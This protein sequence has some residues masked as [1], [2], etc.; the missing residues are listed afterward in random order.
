MTI[1]EDFRDYR[2]TNG[3]S[4]RTIKDYCYWIQ[5]FFEFTNKP[6]NE[7]TMKDVTK[8]VQHMQGKKNVPSTIN[9]AISAINSFFDFCNDYGIY[10]NK[11]HYK[12]IKD[13]EKKARLDKRDTLAPNQFDEFVFKLEDYF[14]E[15][16]NFT[17]ARKWVVL[18]LLIYGVLRKFEATNLLEKN[19]ERLPSG[20][21]KIEFIGKGGAWE[22]CTLPASFQEP[23][24]L[25][26]SFKRKW[27]FD[28]PNLLCTFNNK[29]MYETAFNNDVDWMTKFTGIDLSLSPHRFRH[30]GLN[31][32]KDHDCPPEKVRKAARHKNIKT[33][34]DNYFHNYDNL[35][36]QEAATSYFGR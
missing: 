27:K 20:L 6:Y 35:A 9:L 1:I 5:K 34:M 3:K 8:F 19:V 21:Y 11:V 17:N 12:Q 25:Y 30:A 10:E 29:P 4:Q 23:Y 7:T 28:C 26:L 18:H 14:R 32:L 36:D 24:E 15:H 22:S 2:I 13:K 16:E 33:T 31:Y